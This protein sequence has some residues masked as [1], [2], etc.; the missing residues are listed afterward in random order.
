MNWVT[1]NLKLKSVSLVLAIS[2]WFFVKGITSDSRVVESVPLEIRVKPGMTLV[3]SSATMVTV[4]VRGTR[5]DIRQSSRAELSAVLD[6]TNEDRTGAWQERLS[7]RAIR[8]PPRVAVVSVVPDQVTVRV[9]QMVDR[10][11]PVKLAF[12]GELPGG[13]ELEQALATPPKVSV[14]GPKTLLDGLTTI[15][16]L[17]IDLTGRR[18]SFRERVDLTSADPSVVPLRRRWIEVDVRIGEAGAIDSPPATGKGN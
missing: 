13:R 8:H 6:L 14:R 15:E 12:M 18:V 1:S 11:L 9:D 5:E 2:T 4:V 3:Q 7:P 16:T 17:P 10:E